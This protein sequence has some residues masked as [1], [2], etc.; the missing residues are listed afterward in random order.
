MSYLNDYLKSLSE[1]RKEK[2]SQLLKKII[3]NSFI[4]EQKK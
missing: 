2:I 1:C 4:E 3:D